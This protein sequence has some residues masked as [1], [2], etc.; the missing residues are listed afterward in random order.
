MSQ[1]RSEVPTVDEA[2]DIQRDGDRVRVMFRGRLI[3]EHRPGRPF[4]WV[5]SGRLRYHDSKGHYTIRPLH[6]VR[7]PC[8]TLS[9]REDDPQ[10]GE[11][12]ALLLVSPA[13]I[14]VRFAVLGD[15]LHITFPQW[16]PDVSNVW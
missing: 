12:R 4:V 14:A 1:R 11:Q 10:S 6:I 3:A 16:Q 15:E 5:G 13:G 7:R 8:R 9:V 2:L